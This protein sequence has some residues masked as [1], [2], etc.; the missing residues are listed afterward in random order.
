M[1]TITMAAKYKTSV[2]DPGVAG[3]LKMV[4]PPSSRGVNHSFLFSSDNF[5]FVSS[6][7]RGEIGVYSE[8]STAV[9]GKAQRRV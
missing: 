5:A 9:I 3:V 8:R 1:T 4:S 6:A 2:K 7:E